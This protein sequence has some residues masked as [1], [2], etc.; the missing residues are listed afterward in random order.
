MSY[1]KGYTN[2]RNVANE[3]LMPDAGKLVMDPAQKMGTGIIKDIKRTVGTHWLSE[4]TNFNGKTIAVTLLV[5]IS[6]IAPTLTFGAVYGKVTDNKIGTVETILA[7]CW[8]GV[9]YALIGGM[10]LV[11]TTIQTIKEGR[12]VYGMILE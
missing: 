5:F 8:V 12:N 1:S 11:S 4:M 9:T 2:G 7:T 10:P 3:E 6:V